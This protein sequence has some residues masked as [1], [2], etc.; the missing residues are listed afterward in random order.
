MKR[1]FNIALQKVHVFKLLKKKTFW[2][3]E[4]LIDD[5]RNLN[6]MG[7]FLKRNI[8]FSFHYLICINTCF[9][10]ELFLEEN[11]NVNDFKIISF[12][13]FQVRKYL[14]N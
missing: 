4:Q 2:K 10:S 5:H 13:F 6:I 1:I 11:L 8:T 3:A 12:F 9:L 14:K 7:E